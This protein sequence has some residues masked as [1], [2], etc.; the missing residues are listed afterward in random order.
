VGADSSS[1]GGGRLAEAS[2]FT[3]VQ[4]HSLDSSDGRLGES[5]RSSGEV[6]EVLTVSLQSG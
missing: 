3:R 4:S 6:R 2:A 5:T 1:P